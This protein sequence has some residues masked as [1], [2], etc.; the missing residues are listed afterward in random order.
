MYHTHSLKIYIELPK[1]NSL[2]AK[3]PPEG[4]PKPGAGLCHQ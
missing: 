4:L 3:E 2:N 1:K